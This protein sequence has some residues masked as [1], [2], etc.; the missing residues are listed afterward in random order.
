MLVN[1][2]GLPSM[3][4]KGSVR[5]LLARLVAVPTPPLLERESVGWLPVPHLVPVEVAALA[6]NG[7]AAGE[8]LEQAPG[9]VVGNAGHQLGQ[10]GR[11]QRPLHDG[12]L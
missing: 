7:S 2:K 4:V 11:W 9:I 10:I 3:P 5:A 8:D 6:V 12:A 1:R